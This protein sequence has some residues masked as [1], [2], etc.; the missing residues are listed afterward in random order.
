MNVWV[1]A[2]CFEN[3]KPLLL[4]SLDGARKMDMYGSVAIVGGRGYLGQALYD[5]LA[6]Q[7]IHC[8]IVGRQSAVEIGPTASAEYR[9]SSPSLEK[10]ISGATTVV[11]L[12]TVTTPAIG[13][14]DPNLD[15]EN[16]KFTLALLNACSK[17]KVRHLIYASSGGTVYGEASAP[18]DE[19]HPTNPMSSYAIAKVACENYLRVFASTSAKM[20]TILRV[21]NP[22]GG[23][24]VKK[25]GQG[26]ISYL[27][28]Q[29]AKNQEV[30]LYGNTVRDYV[31]VADV[32]S[33]FSLA[34]EHPR[35]FEIYNISTGVGTCLVDLA[36]IV[37]R[38]LNKDA[39]LVV[40][41]LRPYDL[42]YNVL[43]N[44]KAKTILEWGPRYELED[45]LKEYL[46]EFSFG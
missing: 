43:K 2:R 12:A 9:S 28:T 1:A 35:Q 27:A 40:G 8:W 10:S 30:S 4:G 37:A 33:A 42:S 24:Q 26:V 19:Q 32:V 41:E 14:V 5:H 11:H 36:Q 17:E 45:G 31:N 29:I 20:V 46:K 44:E 7:G 3:K 21:S 25:G 15:V 6:G 38:I 39:R 18:V 22:Y 16:I 13:A 23:C 34:I